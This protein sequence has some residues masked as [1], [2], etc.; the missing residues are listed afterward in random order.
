MENLQLPPARAPDD[1]NTAFRRIMILMRTAALAALSFS[2]LCFTGCS[3]APAPA[4]DTKTTGAAPPAHFTVRSGSKAPEGKYME[5]VGFRVSESKPG[6][7]TIQFGVVNHSEADLGDLKMTINLRTAG[8]NPNDPPLVSFPAK[9]TLG[10]F[11]LKNV[12]VEVPTKMRAYELPDWQFLTADFE[13]G[14]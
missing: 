13:L 5:L 12:S 11:D 14:Q 4:K 6:Q 9:V 8:A 3:S 1:G 2:V 10:P 7:L